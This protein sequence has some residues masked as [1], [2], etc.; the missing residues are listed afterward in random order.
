MKFPTSNSYFRRDEFH[1]SQA[2]KLF[3][4]GIRGA[5]PSRKR[6]AAFTMIEVAISLAIIGFA[7]VAIIGVLPYGMNT[8]RD[9]REETVINQDATMLIE[10]IRNGAYAHDE[11]TNY[12]YAVTNHWTQYDP[13]GAVMSSGTLGYTYTA[14]YQNQFLTNGARIIGLLSTPQFTTD[15]I[16]GVPIPSLAFGGYSNHVTAYVRSISGL[17]AEKPPQN[18]QLMQDNAFAYRIYCVNAAAPADTNLF[19]L[20]PVWQ[21]NQQY[22]KNDTVIYNWSFWKASADTK[23]EFPGVALVWEKVPSFSLDMLGVQHELRL[24]FYWPLLPNGKTL[25]GP[26]TYRATIAG[27]LMTTNFPGFSQTL[28]LYQPQSFKQ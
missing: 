3:R 5:R 15:P 2:G 16:I 18:N 6:S 1:Q 9:N 24:S 22:Y 26:Q 17:A 20:H 19:Y 25:K 8:Q 12:I 23:G 10:A 4:W 13:N 11:L 27:Q 21:L 14:A 7:L 28:Y